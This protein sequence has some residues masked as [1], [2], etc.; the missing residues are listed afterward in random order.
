[1]GR[2]FSFETV[3]PQFRDF[4][5]E[6]QLQIAN[7]VATSAIFGLAVANAASLV[8]GEASTQVLLDTSRAVLP[9]FALVILASGLTTLVNKE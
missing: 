9:V 6:K 1:M 4:V 7:N 3:P 8:A 5:K 2:P